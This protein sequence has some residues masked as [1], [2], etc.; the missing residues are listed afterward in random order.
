MNYAI[1]IYIAKHF[2]NPIGEG[3][4]LVPA[5]DNVGV[6]KRLQAASTTKKRR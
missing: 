5:Q 1:P 4:G 2:I 3:I 6:G